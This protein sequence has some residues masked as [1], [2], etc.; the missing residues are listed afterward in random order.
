MKLHLGFNVFI[1]SAT[2]GGKWRPGPAVLESN[3][4]RG[5]SDPPLLLLHTNLPD[6]L[7]KGS[8]S[9]RQDKNYT[10]FLLLFLKFKIKRETEKD[11]KP[12][13]TKFEMIHIPHSS[14]SPTLVPSV[15]IE[16]W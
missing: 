6:S 1:A 12:D 5:G 4:F 8:F 3:A 15:S 10:F 7:I 9:T 14:P 16:V 2:R 11:E 13:V